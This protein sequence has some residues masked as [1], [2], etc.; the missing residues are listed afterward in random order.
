MSRQWRNAFPSSGVKRSRSGSYPLGAGPLP[1]HL[2]NALGDAT[3]VV[4]PRADGI[5]WMVEG[6][7]EAVDRTDVSCVDG[8]LQVIHGG[9]RSLFGER[10]T[11]SI[12]RNDDVDVY[13]TVPRRP[14]NAYVNLALGD[15]EVRGAEFGPATV[16]IGKGDAEFEALG[17]GP[18]ALADADPHTPGA[19]AGAEAATESV[20]DVKMGDIEVG[21]GGRL[22]LSTKAGDVDVHDMTGDVTVK[23]GAGDTAVGSIRRGDLVAESGLGDIH[24]GVPRGTAVLLDCHSSVGDVDSR[25]TAGE[26]DPQAPRVSIAAKTR[27]GDVKIGYA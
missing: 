11:A 7:A 20:V 25:L 22:R 10:M 2:E 12:V 26:P 16:R 27:L 21:T 23:V 5:Q 3:I 13:L 15:L 9:R 4:D 17:P 1:L 18:A 19:P 14:A 24:V 8:V 6:K